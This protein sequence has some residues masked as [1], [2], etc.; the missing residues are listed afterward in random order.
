[1]NVKPRNK[2]P[3]GNLPAPLSSFIG[4]EHEIAEVIQ[5]LSVHRLVTLT[6]AGGSGKTRLSLKVASELSGKY[7][8]GIW[9]V[10]LAAVLDPT[11]IPQFVAS[12]LNIEEQSGR[13]LT[14]MLV[15]YLSTRQILL[16][17]DNCEHII[18]ACAHFVENLL[19]N[20][21]DVKV[22][23]TSREALGITGE[24]AWTVPALSLPSLQ[25]WTDSASVPEALPRYE[26][27]DVW[28]FI[29]RFAD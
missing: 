26:E 11:F 12:A 23:A 2:T 8:Y 20:C 9:F 1:M 27:S 22:L 21:A 18:A 15:D 13:A 29:A 16:V 5:L 17:L 24:I 4:R 10:E 19:Q 3:A 6:G 28:L 7:K 25:P 14:D